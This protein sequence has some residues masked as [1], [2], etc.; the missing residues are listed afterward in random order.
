MLFTANW[1]GATGGGVLLRPSPPDTEIPPLNNHRTQNQANKY[2]PRGPYIRHGGRVV[3]RA[4]TSGSLRRPCGGRAVSNG[5]WSVVQSVRLVV[6][7]RSPVRAERMVHA[8]LR[9]SLNR[10][11]AEYSTPSS[12]CTTHSPPLP[13]RSGRRRQSPHD[14]L[15]DGAHLAL[16]VT[17]LLHGGACSSAAGGAASGAGVGR[18]LGKHHVSHHRRRTRRPRR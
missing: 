6:S 5:A 15:L 18:P 9:P 13:L 10:A 12:P 8:P 11:A 16:E 2:P 1:L 3:R 4:M 14:P 17:T 7:V